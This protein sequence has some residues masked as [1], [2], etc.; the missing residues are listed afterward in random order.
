MPD[1]TA[2]T[3]AL[4]Y[5]ITQS[6]CEGEKAALAL[7]VGDTFL[8]AFPASIAAGYEPNSLEGA[9]F[10]SGFMQGLETTFINGEVHTKRRIVVD[11]HNTILSI[12][13]VP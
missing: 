10:V 2:V 6:F 1:H 7:K 5:A 12:E 9:G 4:L 13:E 8:G 3:S 11:H